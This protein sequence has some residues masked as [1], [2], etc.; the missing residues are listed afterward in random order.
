MLLSAA[1]TPPAASG[2]SKPTCSGFSGLLGAIFR[3]IKARRN[4]IRSRPPLSAA[5]GRIVRREYPTAVWSTLAFDHLVGL[6]QKQL[7]H[8]KAEQSLLQRANDAIE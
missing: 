7:R 1:N 6:R 2:P 5:N 8:G 4:K 3:V